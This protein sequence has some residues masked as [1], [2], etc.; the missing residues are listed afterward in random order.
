MSSGIIETKLEHLISQHFS[1]ILSS[2]EKS[3]STL[4]VTSPI[5]GETSLNNSGIYNVTSTPIGRNP[6][7]KEMDRNTEVNSS[8]EVKLT[9]QPQDIKDE[10]ESDHWHLQGARPKDFTPKEKRVSYVSRIFTHE[11]ISNREKS[12]TEKENSSLN[13]SREA[14]VK[15]ASNFSRSLNDSQMFNQSKDYS[16]LDDNSF[17]TSDEVDNTSARSGSFLDQVKKILEESVNSNAND[18][19]PMTSMNAS[20]SSTTESLEPEEE[21]E[22]ELSASNGKFLSQIKKIM[23][24]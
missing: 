12:V 24:P 23:T 1:S 2:Q 6:D 22:M 8:S 3:A 20:S 18:S 19:I 9:R 4:A 21:H 5:Q 11:S 16:G 15:P 10:T 7:S 13:T 14:N 17:E